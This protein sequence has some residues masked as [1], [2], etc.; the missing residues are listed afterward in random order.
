MTTSGQ[1]RTTSSGTP[2]APTATPAAQPQAQSAQPVEITYWHFWADRWGKIQ[3]AV[4]NDYNKTAGQQDHIHV[5]VLIVPWGDLNTKLLAAISGGTPPDCAMIGRNLVATW[6]VKG[7]IL[8]NEDLV[9]ASKTVKPDDWYPVAW[10]EVVWKGKSWALPFE[11]GTYAFLW[12]K[13][14]FQR[15]GLDPE[16]PPKTWIEVDQAAAKLTKADE[17]GGFSQVGF[18]PWQS[19]IDLLGWLAGGEWFD[20]QTLKVTATRPENVKAF[21]WIQSYAKQYGGDKLNRWIQSLGGGMTE[22]D[23]FIKGKIAMKFAGSWELSPIAEYA[24]RL[25]FGVALNPIPEG[26]KQ[27]TINQGSAAVLPKGSKHVNPA[28]QFLSWHCIEGIKKWVDQA[29]DMV[30]RPD[31]AEIIPSVFPNKKFGDDYKLF[32]SQ[33]PTAH[34]EPVFPVIEFWDD[35]LNKASEKVVLGKAT[36][37]EALAEVEKN[38]QAELEKALKG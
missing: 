10:T 5:S 38:T 2:S 9:R 37:E 24:P 32:V 19:R 18:I 21:A 35:Q 14:L 23:P 16:K 3:E 8:S 6:A 28:F 27:T 26:G 4:V 25:N 20:D 15:A 30:S 31:Q 29:A 22:N 12:N 36:P 33:L 7:T 34:H 17:R 11:S 13:D 1:E